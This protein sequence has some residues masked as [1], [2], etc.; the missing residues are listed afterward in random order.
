MK[1]VVIVQRRLTHYRVSLFEKLKT[2]LHERNIILELIVGEGTAAENKKNDTGTLSWAKKIPTTYLA[3][4]RLCWQPIEPHVAEADLVIVTQENKLINN[5][6]LMLRPRRFKLALWGHGANLQSNNPQGLKEKFKRWTTTR[7]DWWFAYT[8][9]SAD[10][11]KKT[12]Y[13][14]SRI[15]VL[16]NSVDTSALSSHK[17]SITDEEISEL[18]H[19]LDFG[20]GPVG[21]YIGSLYPEKRLDFLF[22][23]AD[24][25]H[26]QIPDFRLLIIGAGPEES[27]VQVWCAT[28]TWARWVGARLDREKVAY[29][30]TAHVM[31][32]PGALGLGIM[33]S[34]VCQIP[35]ITTN[36]GTHGPEI[37]YLTN[38]V[39]GVITDDSLE[40]YIEA[41]LCLLRNHQ[42]M[43][44]LKNG[45]ALSAQEY[46][47]ENMARRFSEGIE[48]CLK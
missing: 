18:N 27:K 47:V 39:N 46:S 23:A 24:A 22:A 2:I 43:N 35:I 12:G 31:L 21:V 36:C 41:C 8:Q 11:L 32:N 30:S 1:K 15:T 29:L 13:Q 3:G 33:D 6:L 28:R 38:E 5:H 4:G 20:P 19:A 48:E 16:N 42:K 14:E 44:A 9:L 10:I 45:C 34:F 37:S 25:I 17:Q 40:A 7:A 26:N